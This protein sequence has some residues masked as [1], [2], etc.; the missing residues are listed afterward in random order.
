MYV[1]EIGLMRRR[2]LV[3]RWKDWVKEYMHERGAGRAA[4]LQQAKRE[5]LD[6][7]KMRLRIGGLFRRNEASETI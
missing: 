2:R 3:I 4:G 7:E 1:S 5:C 6:R